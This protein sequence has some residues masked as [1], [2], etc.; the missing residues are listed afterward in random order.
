MLLVMSIA[1]VVAAAELLYRFHRMVQFLAQFLFHPVSYP[2]C[3]YELVI[4]T[5]LFRPKS[6]KFEREKNEFQ[7]TIF[8]C[9]ECVRMCLFK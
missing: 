6:T 8:R 2:E 3:E 9:L 1:A 4:F 5:R 7:L